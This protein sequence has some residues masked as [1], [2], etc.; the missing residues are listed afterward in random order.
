[1][2]PVSSGHSERIIV[3]RMIAMLLDL[4]LK[5]EEGVRPRRQ[6]ELPNC[7]LPIITWLA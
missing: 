1:M 4:Y 2:M 3:R 7:S 6:A 5:R